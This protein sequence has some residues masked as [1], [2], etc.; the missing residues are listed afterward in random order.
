[1]GVVQELKS[2]P[3]GV[4]IGENLILLLTSEF[5]PLSKVSPDCWPSKAGQEHKRK[6]AHSV[7]SMTIM[8]FLQLPRL[9]SL[10]PKYCV[11]PLAKSQTDCPEPSLS[12]PVFRMF[13][14]TMTTT[15]PDEDTS[16][17]L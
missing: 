6:N 10:F 8:H 3:E 15:G 9:L 14:L 12:S 16:H 5:L 17:Q 2:S 7:F 1:M 13:K 4:R 11:V